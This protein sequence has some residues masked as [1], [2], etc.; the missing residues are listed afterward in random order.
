MAPTLE[1]LDLLVLERICEYLDDDSE[2][3]RNLWAFSS[4][5]RNCYTASAVQRLSQ[6]LLKIPS[7]EDI[8]S[9]LHRWSEILGANGG[10]C[11]V[12]RLKV[13][14]AL[15]AIMDGRQ[16]VVDEKAENDNE[17]WRDCSFFDVHDFCHPPKDRTENRG[18][19]GSA[20]TPEDWLPLN[21]FIVQ[22]LGLRDFVWDYGYFMPPSILFTL[23]S[24]DCR[25]H[26]HKFHLESLIRPRDSPQPIDANE[27]ALLTS[28]CLHSIVIRVG[29][30]T[31]DFQLDYSREAVIQMVAGIAPR[32]AHV[33]MIPTGAGGSLSLNQNV[34]LGKPPWRGFFLDGTPESDLHHAGKLRSL[35]CDRY[36]YRNLNYWA[37]LTDFGNLRCLHLSW[38]DA[39]GIIMAQMAI[40][41]CFKHLHTLRLGEIEDESDEGQESLTLFFENIHPLRQLRLSGYIVSETFDVILRRHGRTLSSLEVS[42]SPSDGVESETPPV[43][44]NKEVVQRL[45]DLCP[46]LEQIKIPLARTRGDIEETGIYR[47]L[48]R[49]PRLRCALLRLQYGIGPV[50]DGSWDE[51][52]GGGNPPAYIFSNPEDLPP[53]YLRE[54]FSNIALD[55]PLAL[56]IFNIVASGGSLKYLSLK[57]D[58]AYTRK[59]YHSGLTDLLRWFSRSWILKRDVR[60]IDTAVEIQPEETARAGKEWI[61]QISEEGMAADRGEEVYVEAFKAL[62]PQKTE[63]WWN[64]WTSLP[65]ADVET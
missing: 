63:E 27:Y 62:W 39:D 28:P 57:I 60:G 30:F 12:R 52:T 61:Y 15:W 29:S 64:D 56:S 48:S 36:V 51:E 2:K 35:I 19:W 33:Q 47:A 16:E 9:E 58:R 65:L 10:H 44:F 42:P 26:M 50:D 31:D 21:D 13:A 20:G 49:L 14:S 1:S 23:T 4:T 25:L 6:V 38:D 55:E 32:L 24:R 43:A 54:L 22:L 5:S 37:S 11:H 34:A 59:L 3:R 40:R 17:G 41:G 8:V 7:P 45:A 53:A 18:R 46:N